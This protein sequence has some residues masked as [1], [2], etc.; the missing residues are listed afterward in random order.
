MKRLILTFAAALTLA[1]AVGA[2]V[3]SSGGPNPCTGPY[4]AIPIA[5]GTFVDFNLNGQICEPNKKD[6]SEYKDDR[7]VKK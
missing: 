5:V 4:H 3:G 6:G 2:P 7:I 1:F